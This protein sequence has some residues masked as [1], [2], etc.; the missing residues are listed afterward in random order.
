MAD[1]IYTTKM[2]DMVDL[3]CFRHYGYTDGSTE[4]V[5]AANPGL[6]AMDPVLGSGVEIALPD[7]GAPEDKPSEIETVKLWD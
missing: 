1:V 6:S 2:G 5:L 4:A 7:L 3:I